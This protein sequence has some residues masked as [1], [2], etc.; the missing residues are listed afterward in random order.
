MLES[1]EIFR[2]QRPDVC[3]W[4][5]WG[6]IDFGIR[7]WRCVNP[8]CASLTVAGRKALRCKRQRK[9]QLATKI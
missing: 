6:N 7:K 9:A 3:T 1:F 5:G 8:L 4:C 2:R